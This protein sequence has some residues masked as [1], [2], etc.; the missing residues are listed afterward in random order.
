MGDQGNKEDAEDAAA[1]T[2]VGAI[3]ARAGYRWWRHN[4]LGVDSVAMPT[5]VPR[6]DIPTALRGPRRCPRGP[7]QLALR[8]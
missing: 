2:L 4:V 5:I 8:T 1:W 3:G 7:F 6:E